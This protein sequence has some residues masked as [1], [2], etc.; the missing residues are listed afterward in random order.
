MG[1]SFQTA[2]RYDKITRPEFCVPDYGGDGSRQVM[3]IQSARL[4]GAALVGCVC[5]LAGP[6]TGELAGSLGRAAVDRGLHRAEDR[7]G[8]DPAED[9]G[10]H[11]RGPV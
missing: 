9:A 8:H 11:A 1:G 2:I 3:R 4:P 5:V 6:D 10:Q 7:A